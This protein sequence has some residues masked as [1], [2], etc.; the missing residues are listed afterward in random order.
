VAVL[1]AGA[2]APAKSPVPGAYSGESS[3]GF[4]VKFR[5]A[6]GKVRSFRLPVRALCISVAS[7]TSYLD[8]VLHHVT[9]EPAKLRARGRFHRTTRLQ[10]ASTLMRV[11]GRVNG[12]KAR[13]SYHIG[14][15]ALSGT[16]IYACQDDGT[17]KATL[18]R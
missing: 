3:K 8:P 6:G 7:A 10:T 16:N 17:W 5:V 12:S 18:Q 14:Y 2:P 15:T 4:P 9:P 11:K 1:A 13:G